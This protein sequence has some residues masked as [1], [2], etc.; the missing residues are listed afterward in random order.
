M[1]YED[2][3][4]KLSDLPY[5]KT[6]FTISRM[7]DVRHDWFTLYRDRFIGYYEDFTNLSDVCKE[8]KRQLCDVGVFLRPSWWDEECEAIYRE[9]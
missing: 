8:L 9:A 5:G 3:K 1:T 4:K 6:G 7:R 2:Y